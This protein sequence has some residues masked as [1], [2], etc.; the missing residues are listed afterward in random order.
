MFSNT[1][2]GEDC[3]HLIG[4]CINNDGEL[5]LEYCKI[6]KPAFETLCVALGD[7]HVIIS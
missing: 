4:K 5:Q 6:T 2:I 1:N 7:K 3:A